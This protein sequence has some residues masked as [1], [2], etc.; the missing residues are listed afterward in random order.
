MRAR[1]AVFV[2]NAVFETG[3]YKVDYVLPGQMLCMGAR[4]GITDT[5]SSQQ[6]CYSESGFL[7]RGGYGEAYK[8]SFN[9]HDIAIKSP[10]YG[11]RSK[12]SDSLSRV[13]NEFYFLRQSYPNEGPYWLQHFYKRSLVGEWHTYFMVMPFVQGKSIRRMINVCYELKH[14][15]MAA[16]LIIL[17][18]AEELQRIHHLRMIHGDLRPGNIL[19]C[20]DG[21]GDFTVHFIDF[22]YAAFFGKPARGIDSMD[23]YKIVPPEKWDGNKVDAHPSQDLYSFA[24]TLQYE[25]KHSVLSKALTQDLYT[26]F[27]SINRLF[28]DGTN[29]DPNLRPTLTDFIQQLTREYDGYLRHLSSIKEHGSFKLFAPKVNQHARVNDPSILEVNSHIGTKHI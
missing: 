26:S 10:K 18:A 13:E 23:E 8:L 6:Y 22:D 27:P 29:D 9:G 3:H 4:V 16:A 7:G 17:R 5:V 1:S 25:I 14:P 19:V 2:N 21:N 15:E 20:P 28:I 24:S 11:W 12:D